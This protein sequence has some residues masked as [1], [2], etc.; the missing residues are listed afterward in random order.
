M[1]NRAG[2]VIFVQRVNEYFL[3]KRD[4]NASECALEIRRRLGVQFFRMDLV[5][6]V[7]YDSD[8]ESKSEAAAAKR[9]WW[10]H[11]ADKSEGRGLGSGEES[12]E[13]EEEAADES[14]EVH[15]YD[16]SRKLLMKEEEDLRKKG[17]CFACGQ[18][19]EE[20]EDALKNGD[21]R[22]HRKCYQ[23]VMQEQRKPTTPMQS[24]QHPK[25]AEDR[26]ERVSS[27][28]A[29]SHK[30]ENYRQRVSS[31]LTGTEPRA[32]REREEG[33]PRSSSP[34]SNDFLSDVLSSDTDVTRS[35]E[36]DSDEYLRLRQRAS[37]KPLSARH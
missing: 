14:S 8:D 28:S 5:K 2:V 20:R 7:G 32:H 23:Q 29:D 35:V 19:I 12:E 27:H 6:D 25:T 1:E 17:N 36:L 26:R 11:P 3:N 37:L 16:I 24:S 9:S 31:M 22:W 13:E 18:R 21:E 34:P 15:G 10:E 33:E 4:F 30:E